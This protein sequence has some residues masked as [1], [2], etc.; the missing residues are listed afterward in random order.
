ML[1]YTSADVMRFFGKRV[2]HSGDIPAGF[3]GTLEEDLKR[4]SLASG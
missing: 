1:S 4:R 2:N 3:N